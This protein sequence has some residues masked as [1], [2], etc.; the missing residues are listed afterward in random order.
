MNNISKNV[1]IF[2]LKEWKYFRLHQ[3]A[4]HSIP[5][6]ATDVYLDGNNLGNFTSQ[7]Q[8]SIIFTCNFFHSVLQISEASTWQYLSIL[9]AIAE[10][11]ISN[12]IL[13]CSEGK[14]G[15]LIFSILGYTGQRLTPSPWT[16]LMSTWMETIWEISPVRNWDQSSSLVILSAPS[17][18]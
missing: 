9:A 5:M 14:L 17:P 10:E 12:A 11:D 6:D 2:S 4:P 13:Y 16:P 8:I 3:S 15:L 1:K 7:E 18:T